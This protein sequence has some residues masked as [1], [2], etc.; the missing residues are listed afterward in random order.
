MRAVSIVAA[1]SLSLL[2]GAPIASADAPAPDAE[3]LFEFDSSALDAASETELNTIAERARETPGTKVVIDAHADSRGT[4]PYNVALSIRRG[5]RVRDYLSSKGVD[6]DRLVLAAYGE[7]GPR[8][9]T[10]AQ[11]R[12]ASITITA[13]PM[14]AIIDGSKPYATAVVWNEPLTIAEIEGPP[15]KIPQTARR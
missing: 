10:F 7:D 14:W 8:R 3:V 12:R 13:D 5:E 6:R 11:D 9:S 15:D 4:P 1:G 2:I